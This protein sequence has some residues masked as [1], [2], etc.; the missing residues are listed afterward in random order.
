MHFNNVGMHIL[1]ICKLTRCTFQAFKSYHL[2]FTR[3]HVCTCVYALLILSQLHISTICILWNAYKHTFCVI[4][5][6]V[7]LNNGNVGT[8]NVQ[9]P[10]TSSSYIFRYEMFVYLVEHM[11]LNMHFYYLYMYIRIPKKLCLCFRQHN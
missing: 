10:C 5:Y 9:T 2:I 11:N 1:N 6:F 4:C 3:M 8:L 7:F